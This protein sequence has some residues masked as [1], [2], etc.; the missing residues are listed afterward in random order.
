MFSVYVMIIRN[1]LINN[2]NKN[3]LWNV[4]HSFF[5]AYARINRKKFINLRVD[6]KNGHNILRIL[7]LRGGVHFRLALCLVLAIE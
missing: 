5:L 6:C 2:N 4:L 7:P 3:L 1:N